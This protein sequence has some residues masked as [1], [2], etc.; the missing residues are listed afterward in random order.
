MQKEHINKASQ[1]SDKTPFAMR[2]LEV[3]NRCGFLN[4]EL[5]EKIS[6]ALDVN[7]PQS[8]FS[9]W[10]RGKIPK[11]YPVERI[12]TILNDIEAE[13]SIAESAE[14]YIAK[15]TVANTVN[16][17]LKVISAKQLAVISEESIPTISQWKDAK[18]SVRTRK[19]K[20]VT[21]KVLPFIDYYK[22]INS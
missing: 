15:D 2:L 19:W 13:Y 22:K 1:L 4:K 10:L 5:L 12:F 14:T 21:N 9:A 18:Y 3:R 6:V 16:E 8:N 20:V 11:K 7:I 17:W